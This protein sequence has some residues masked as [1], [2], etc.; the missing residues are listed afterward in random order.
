MI[1]LEIRTYGEIDVV[2]GS[3][4]KAFPYIDVDAGLRGVY[5]GLDIG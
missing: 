1:D 2:G 3:S 4:I 5:G